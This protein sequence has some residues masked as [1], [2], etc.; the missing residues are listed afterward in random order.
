MLTVSE[1]AKTR[2]DVAERIVVTVWASTVVHK[3][4]N[5]DSFVRGE[6]DDAETDSPIGVKCFRPNV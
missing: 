4:W 6:I 1:T 5:P 2:V 3:D